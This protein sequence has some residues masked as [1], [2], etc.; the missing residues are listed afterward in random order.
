MRKHK[1][2]ESEQDC[3]FLTPE[4]LKSFPGFKDSSDEELLN[5]ISSLKELSLI[6]YAHIMKSEKE[7]NGS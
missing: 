6:L 7:K 2:N 3:P 1:P 5:V 4:M